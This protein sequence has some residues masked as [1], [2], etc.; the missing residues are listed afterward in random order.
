MDATPNSADD[1]DLHDG[2]VALNWAC[3]LGYVDVVQT[4]LLHDHTHAGGA[5]A[6]NAHIHDRDGHTP[7]SAA[8]AAGKLGVVKLLLGHTGA[9]GGVDVNFASPGNKAAL[10]LAAMHGHVRVVQALL[11][12]EGVD[13]E[14]AVDSPGAEH[15][16][17]TPL[18]FAAWMGHAQIAT[19]LVSVR[20]LQKG[21]TCMLL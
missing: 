5:P 6:L 15:D 9:R 2:R 18:L 16:G 7:L 1:R 20:L 21:G 3:R 8:A 17:C 11:E 12:V 14:V 13:V 19:Q 10:S 4:L